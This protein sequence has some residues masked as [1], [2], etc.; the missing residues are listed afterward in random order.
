MRKNFDVLVVGSGASA[1]NAAWPLVEAGLSVGM[2]DPGGRDET[3][4]PIV[5]GDDFR[6]IRRTDAN[7]HRYFLGDEFEGIPFGPV[8]VGAQLTP[9]RQFITR[10]TEE[11]SPVEAGALQAAQTFARGGLGA[12]WGASAM[13]YTD[14]DLA[15]WPVGRSELQP[16]YDAVSKRVGISGPKRDDLSPHVGPLESLMPPSRI[17]SNADWVYRRYERVRGEL[18]ARG[19]RMGQARLAV[20]TRRHRGR[21]PL[22]YGDMEFWADQD[23]AVYRPAFTIDELA[24]RGAFHELSGLMAVRYRENP[25]D[26]SVEVECLGL[27]TNESVTLS[28]RRLVLAAGAIGTARIVLESLGRRNEPVPFLTN[29][30]TYLPCLVPSRIGR[31]TRDRRHS[32][33]QLT[34]IYDPD[35]TGR[36]AVQPQLYSY[37]SLLSFKLLKESP[38]PMRESI[39]LIRAI[40]EYLVIVGIFHPDFPSNGRRLL[41]DDAGTLVI[42]SGSV[43]CAARRACEDR[44]AGFLRR[45]GC[46]PLKRIDPGPGASIHYAG[47]LPM[48]GEAAAGPLTCDADGRLR[49]GKLVV[50]ADGSTFPTLPAKGLTFTLMANADRIGAALAKEMAS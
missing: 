46:M 7:Q 34:M 3:Y 49:G 20:C 9:P 38:L 14:A 24:T 17:D 36:N 6:T 44:V 12:G 41:L 39:P 1:A 40:Q 22:G 43:E 47:T 10:G 30:Y 5:P 4:A 18:L 50:V 26:E 23:R 25:A 27:R 11:R 28:A 16:H 21:G 31:R 33:T 48:R 2:I 37:R 29:P 42:R 13:P 32:L 8:R 45:V 19:F 35:G 15:D